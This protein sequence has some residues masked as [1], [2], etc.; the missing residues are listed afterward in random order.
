[1][2]VPVDRATVLLVDHVDQPA[3]EAVVELGRI[4]RRVPADANPMVRVL[5]QSDS[6]RD[7]VFG[8]T[9]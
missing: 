5:E 4:L 3:R 8:S 1:M 9:W 2:D 7:V 6:I